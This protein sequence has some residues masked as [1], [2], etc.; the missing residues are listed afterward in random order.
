MS[1]AFWVLALTGIMITW[2]ASSSKKRKLDDPAV[3]AAMADTSKIMEIAQ[4]KPPQLPR[5]KMTLEKL[6]K[7]I[8][9]AIEEEDE[10]ALAELEALLIKMERKVPPRKIIPKSTGE[11]E[12]GHYVI[13]TDKLQNSCHIRLYENL[14]GWKRVVRGHW[15]G[16]EALC[17]NKEKELVQ[18][19][20]QVAAEARGVII[21]ESLK[22]RAPKP[23]KLSPVF[24]IPAIVPASIPRVQE[25]DIVLLGIVQNKKPYNLS[26]GRE[27]ARALSVGVAGEEVQFKPL[28]AGLPGLIETYIRGQARGETL[29]RTG[30]VIPMSKVRSMPEPEL[31]KEVLREKPDEPNVAMMKLIRDT[32]GLTDEQR[33]NLLGQLK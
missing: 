33:M 22:I 24:P 14:P 5:S 20:H 11:I 18:I 21:P 25:Y 31:Q 8:V 15:R 3:Q 2:G 30:P 7:K 32:P 9:T 1:K 23:P 27:I 4:L 19:I 29:T 28:H 12:V 16:D 13:K 26:R 17:K 6:K 10:E